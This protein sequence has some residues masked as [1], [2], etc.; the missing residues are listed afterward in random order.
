MRFQEIYFGLDKS[1]KLWNLICKACEVFSD[2]EFLML[3]TIELR[4]QSL[5]ADGLIVGQSG[6]GFMCLRR[7][8]T[9]SVANFLSKHLE[10]ELPLRVF[11]LGSTFSTKGESFQLGIEVIGDDSI[12]AEALVLERI[13]KFLRVSA[14]DDFKIIM[15]DVSIVRWLIKGNQELFRAVLEKNLSLLSSHKELK[16][17]VLAQGG[18]ELLEGFMKKYPSLRKSLERMIELSELVGDVEF[19]LSEIRS[20]EYYSGMV[21]EFFCKRS[22]NAIAGGGRYDGL[23]K[24]LGRDLPA[25]G[26]AIYLDALLEL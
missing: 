21:F 13:K 19:D 14:F 11:Y 3:P 25:V 15:G 20:Q 6:S 9:E 7:D 12:S 2:F 26:G 8:W 4:N 17:L 1:K 5:P 16:E 22:P 24:A 18:R 23:Y 10:L